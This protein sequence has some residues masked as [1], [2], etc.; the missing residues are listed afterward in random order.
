M[1]TRGSVIPLFINQVRN[2]KPITLT[3]PNMTRFMMSL[4]D[5][6]NL[7]LFAFNN[8]ESGDIFVQKSP[9]AT[10]ELLAEVIKEILYKPNHTVKT[11]GTRHGEKLHETLL[12]REEM[13][14]AVDLDNYYKLCPDSRDLNYNSYFEE[15]DEVISQAEEYTSENT[16]RL[17]K[18]ELT[19]MLLD[20]EEIQSDLK[21]FKQESK[22]EFKEA[23]N[24]AKKPELTS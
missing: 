16:H 5:A 15:G 2:N 11:I 22:K 14:R 1:A 17:N 3:D 20:L 19:K 9:A 7:V 12:T 13:A 21:E 23:E 4:N 24:N 18:Q 8:G 6:V 10:M